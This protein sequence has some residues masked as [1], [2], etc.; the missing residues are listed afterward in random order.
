MSRAKGHRPG[1]RHATPAR[2]VIT[3]TMQVAMGNAQALAPSDVAAQTAIVRT[4][5]DSLRKGQH[6]DQHW[7]SLADTANMAETLCTM[8][9]GSGPQAEQAI[10]AAQAAL[11]AVWQRHSARGSW[12]LYPAEIQALEWLPAIHAVQLAACSYG[13]FERAFHSTSQRIAQARAGNAGPG[14]VVLG[15]MGAH[16]E[17]GA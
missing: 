10:N 3:N 8:G 15:D 6:C 11:A 1:R 14:T 16:Q 17:A 5:L 12:T 9:L 2:R 4:A 13:E 7:R